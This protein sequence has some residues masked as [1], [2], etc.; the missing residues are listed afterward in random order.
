MEP[1]TIV[2]W[3]AAGVLIVIGPDALRDLG[4]N[5]LAQLASLLGAVCYAVSGVYG[6]RFGNLSPA[7]VS[8]SILLVASIVIAPLKN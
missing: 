4:M 6:R 1:A 2:L 8:A 5:V 3:I 7:V